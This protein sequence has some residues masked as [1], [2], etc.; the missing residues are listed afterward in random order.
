MNAISRWRN[1]KCLT[2]LL[3]SVRE[4]LRYLAYV[5]RPG[6]SVDGKVQHLALKMDIRHFVLSFHGYGDNGPHDFI[7]AN[8]LDF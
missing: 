3:W 5:E 6:L 8:A 4:T 1:L 7:E 2:I